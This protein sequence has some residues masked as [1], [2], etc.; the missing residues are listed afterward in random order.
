MPVIRIL[1]WN[2]CDLFYEPYSGNVVQK[3][4]ALATHARRHRCSAICCQEAWRPSKWNAY[5]TNWKFPM[6]DGLASWPK[7][8]WQHFT[9][10]DAAGEDRCVHKGFACCD[11]GK[12]V[13]Y[14]VHLQADHAIGFGDAGEIRARQ[15]K[16][17]RDHMDTHGNRPVLAVGDFNPV[18]KPVKHE[19]CISAENGLDGAIARNIPGPLSMSEE[20]TELSDHPI[21]VVSFVLDT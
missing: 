18:C 7:G 17:L 4:A 16:Q 1:S 6:G 5:D 19:I 14:N 12:Y 10:T 21:I 20:G 15:M 2:V 3:K 13:L 9:F 11:M 8:M